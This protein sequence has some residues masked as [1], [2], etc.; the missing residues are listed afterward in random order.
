MTSQ[1]HLM[2][3]AN[4]GACLMLRNIRAWFIKGAQV[5]QDLMSHI[6]FCSNMQMAQTREAHAPK[7][8]GFR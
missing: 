7:Q 6:L 2:A 5:G 1:L 8:A 3:S 4:V